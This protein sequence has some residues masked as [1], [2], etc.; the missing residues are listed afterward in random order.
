MFLAHLGLRSLVYTSGPCTPLRCDVASYEY[1]AVNSWPNEFMSDNLQQCRTIAYATAFGAFTTCATLLFALMGTM[2]RMKFSSD[3]NI[4]KALGMITDLCGFISLT[5]TLWN[6]GEVCYNSIEREYTDSAGTKFEASVYLGPGY[7]CYLVC[8]FGAFM[9]ALFH[10]LTP[11]PKK[12]GGC[13]PKLPA[14]LLKRL[15]TDGDGKVSWKELKDGYK[16]L[17]ADRNQRN[18]VAGG[19]SPLVEPPAS[20]SASSGGAAGKPSISGNATEGHKAV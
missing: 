6:M 13:V 5:F 20:S 18:S 14:S 17:V 3:A 7:I 8:L 16:A 10:W 4:Q 11:M 15:D 2:N 9:R 1:G 19:T 12:G